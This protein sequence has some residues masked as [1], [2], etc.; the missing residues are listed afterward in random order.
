MDF[1]LF[2]ELTTFGYSHDDLYW[3]VRVSCSNWSYLLVYHSFS[4]LY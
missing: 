1:Y 2:Y 4:Q 3:V